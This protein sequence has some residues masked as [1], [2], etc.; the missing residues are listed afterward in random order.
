MASQDNGGASYTGGYDLSNIPNDHAPTQQAAEHPDQTTQGS[1]REGDRLSSI[2]PTQEEFFAPNAGIY[3]S[4][5][6]IAVVADSIP[7]PED[8]IRDLANQNQASALDDSA[9]M[10]RLVRVQTQTEYVYVAPDEAAGASVAE[11]EVGEE[12]VGDLEDGESML[13]KVNEF[14]KYH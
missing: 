10:P 14:R 5:L 9:S 1:V 11:E 8:I 4:P 2:Y 12:E 6:I 3:S 7:F 13:L